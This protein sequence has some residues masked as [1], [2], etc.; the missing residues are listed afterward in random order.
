MF[1]IARRTGLSSS[2]SLSSGS[3]AMRSIA[4]RRSGPSL[5]DWIRWRLLYVRRVEIGEG[6]Y[7]IA[8][9]RNERAISRYSGSRLVFAQMPTK[10]WRISRRFFD[11]NEDS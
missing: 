5:R 2:R 3:I 11:S 4:R 8:V 7:L 1:T 9:D 6:Y 10:N